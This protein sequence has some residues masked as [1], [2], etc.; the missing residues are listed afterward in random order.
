MSNGILLK[1]KFPRTQLEF[2][3]SLN[4]GITLEDLT[5]GSRKKVFWK[6]TKGK[7]HI[8]EASP[9]QRTSGGNL[10][11]CPICAGKLVIP[12][13]SLAT[14]F[15]EL[16]NE[17]DY[18]RNQIAPEKVTEASSK[19]VW[20]QCSKYH[21]H[22]WLASPKQRTRQGNTCPFCN[23]L[24]VRFP[25]LSREWHP[26][27]NG[28]LKPLGIAYSSHTKVWWKCDKGFDH[29]W[30]AS[31]NLRTSMKTGCPICSGHQ[32]VKSNS[33]ASMLPSLA[34]QWD[35]KKNKVEPDKIYFRSTQK[36]W[37]KCPA[38]EDHQWQ[39]TV[40]SRANGIGCPICS[41]RKIARSNSLGERNPEIAL[42]WHP[43]ANKEL[44]PFLVTP[45][46]G[47]LVWW[48][49]PRG[50]EHQWQA[51]V[52]NVVNGSSCPVCM[53]RKIT[54]ENSFSVLFPDILK[55]W[56]YEK[57]RNIDPSKISAGTKVKV[58]WLCQ[59]NPDHFW[60][61][62]VRDRTQKDSGCPFCANVMNVSEHKML[63]II[64][65][66][67]NGQEIRYCYRPDW[68]KRME[69]DVYLPALKIG[70]EYQGVQHF[71]PVEF[72]GGEETYIAQAER[73]RLKKEICDSKKVILLYVYYDEKLS[74]KLVEDKLTNAGII[75]EKR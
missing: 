40:K 21:E 57:N 71:K 46:S 28:E 45:Y 69:I 70:F 51:T 49:C 33:L 56:D 66:I 25:E 58:W 60:Y 50:A 53:N 20:W 74:K 5:L 43:S 64:K 37:W 24:A 15:P 62:T 42:L 3:Q 54:N 61:A 10:R 12:E 44:T 67:F 31:P 19:K 68:L 75:Y 9:N 47:K 34:A 27:K 29:V 35:F 2:E 16:S 4:K 11:G 73:D 6:C 23:S 63:E 52:A 18:S 14:K 17:W 36:A 32:V 13:T 41:G 26:T 59:R 72:F 38:G 8:W 22:H 65:D 7:T 55:E 1:E 39:S 48:K 30:Q